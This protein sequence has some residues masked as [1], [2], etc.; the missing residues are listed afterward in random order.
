MNI[1]STSIFSTN[2]FSQSIFVT[3]ILAYPHW[4][5]GK[6]GLPETFAGTMMAFAVGI[7]LHQIT[8]IWGWYSWWMFLLIADDDASIE[9]I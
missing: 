5:W 3:N 4:P 1:F 7:F 6:I 8:N 2:I 9:N